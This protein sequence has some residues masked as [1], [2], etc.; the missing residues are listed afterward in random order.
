VTT[1]K[2]TISG[3]PKTFMLTGN[4][5]Q[6]FWNDSYDFYCFMG[7]CTGWTHNIQVSS[8]SDSPVKVELGFY[9][10]ATR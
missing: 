4:G 3:T 10:S 5:S 2:L 9:V 8:T 6:T 7:M 1:I